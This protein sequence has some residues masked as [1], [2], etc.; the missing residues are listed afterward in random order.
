[1][2]FTLDYHWI[3][4]YHVITTKDAILSLQ[5]PEIGDNTNQSRL[6]RRNPSVVFYMEI[7]KFEINIPNYLL[8]RQDPSPILSMFIIKVTLNVKI[9]SREHG[10]VMTK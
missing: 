7:L 6:E 10:Y 1:M 4:C 2:S 9:E 5:T 8:T 3:L